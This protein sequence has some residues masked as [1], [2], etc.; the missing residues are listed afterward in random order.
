MTSGLSASPVRRLSNDPVGG[1]RAETDGR[2]FQPTG[3]QDRQLLIDELRPCVFEFLIAE[4]A[5][6]RA[7]VSAPAVLVAVGRPS[8]PAKSLHLTSR[9]IIQALGCLVLHQACT[10]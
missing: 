10:I 1:G 7:T 9:R 4:G 2:A 8:A 3:T 6:A 5:A